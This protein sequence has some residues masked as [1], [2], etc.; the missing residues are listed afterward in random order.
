MPLPQ[1]RRGTD[2]K[3]KNH[4]RAPRSTLIAYNTSTSS[5]KHTKEEDEERQEKKKMSTQRGWRLTAGG[6]E[7]KTQYLP[8]LGSSLQLPPLWSQ[9]KKDKRKRL[10]KN[11][12]QIIST[13]IL[14]FLNKITQTPKQCH[15][16][17]HLADPQLLPILSA[18]LS[19]LRFR[20][21]E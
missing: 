13:K 8:V 20:K 4:P 10:Q 15:K 21:E 1:M 9:Q 16:S 18:W 17:T 12:S 19:C 14:I 11:F 6:E 3:V 2:G 5:I 7:K